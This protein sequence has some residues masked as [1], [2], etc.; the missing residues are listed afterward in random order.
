MRLVEQAQ[1]SRSRA[2][3]LADRAAEAAGRDR[4]GA[5]MLLTQIPPM[6]GDTTCDHNLLTFAKRHAHS[7]PSSRIQAIHRVNA[8]AS[9]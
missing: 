5:G 8:D 4:I 2:Q 6:P 3:A 7:A 9:P 1:S